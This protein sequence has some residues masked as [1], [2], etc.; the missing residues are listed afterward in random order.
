MY[1]AAIDSICGWTL[2][3][4]G[5]VQIADLL[6]RSSCYRTPQA[7]ANKFQSNHQYVEIRISSKI[8]VGFHLSILLCFVLIMAEHMATISFPRSG[9]AEKFIS[10]DN[11]QVSAVAS[12]PNAWRPWRISWDCELTDD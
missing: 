12:R 1:T 2:A 6:A 5:R 7:N 9:A 3:S 11:S 10:N 8:Y 4:P